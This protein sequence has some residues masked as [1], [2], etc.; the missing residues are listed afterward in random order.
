MSESIH[1]YHRAQV[2]YAIRWRK[3]PEFLA[4]AAS[5]AFWIAY[6]VRG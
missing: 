4:L 6:L 3:L 1:H 2:R 5:T